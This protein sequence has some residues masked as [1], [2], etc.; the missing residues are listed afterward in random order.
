MDR[1]KIPIT[2]G[3][4]RLWYGMD[5]KN[6]NGW[7]IFFDIFQRYCESHR[8][9]H[10]YGHVIQL[11]GEFKGVRHLCQNPNAV[12]VDLYCHDVI[13]VPGARD[14]EERSAEFTCGMLR[15][16]RVAEPFIREASRL[17]LLSKKHTAAKND[18]DGCI[19]IDLDLSI[20]GQPPAVYDVYE[21]RVRKEWVL[22]KAVSE[23]EFIHGR[24]AF[25]T[26]FLR[27]ESVYL[28]SY[29]REKY[30]DAAQKNLKRSRENLM[31]FA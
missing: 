15:H 6:A 16:A 4:F 5:A 22:T 23:E 8:Y 28:T 31:Q 26:R 9:Y 1:K 29:F 24:A 20:L 21:E 12:E 30:E 11:L 13:Y 2:E 3:W 18:T 25:L 19:S 7:E 10:D 27:R 14:N 17:V